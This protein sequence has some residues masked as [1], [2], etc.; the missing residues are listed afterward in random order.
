MGSPRGSVV[1]VVGVGEL[2]HHLTEVQRGELGA[3]AGV[4]A[5]DVHLLEVVDGH[6]AE[7]DL[8]VDDVGDLGGVEPAVLRDRGQREP[9]VVGERLRDARGGRP[10]EPDLERALLTSGAQRA[11]PV[12]QRD[13]RVPL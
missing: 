8:G 4:D 6:L 3:A 2:T 9:V 5:H 13:P 1:E 12:G 7:A 11:Q 10:E